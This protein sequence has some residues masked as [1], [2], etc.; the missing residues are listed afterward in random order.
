MRLFLKLDVVTNCL[1]GG[2]HDTM[3]SCPRHTNAMTDSPMNVCSSGIGGHA[4]FQEL[5][6]TVLKVDFFRSD[7]IANLTD[8]QVSKFTFNAA[9]A[10]LNVS[11]IYKTRIV[12]ATVVHA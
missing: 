7:N 10:A 4:T 1:D 2:L 5:Q 12:D 11:I 9:A 3:R 8:N 6:E